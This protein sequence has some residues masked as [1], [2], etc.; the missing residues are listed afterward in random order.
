MDLIMDQPQKEMIWKRHKNQKNRE[1][2]KM[3]KFIVSLRWNV[4]LII[5]QYCFDDMA[6][7]FFLLRG[8]CN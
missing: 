1:K 2:K 5:L 8:V 7:H 4:I 6:H 3:M